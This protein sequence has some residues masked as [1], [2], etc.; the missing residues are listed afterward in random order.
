MKVSIEFL[1]Y[2]DDVYR[3]AIRPEDTLLT[4]SMDTIKSLLKV[5][6]ID[7]PSSLPFMTLFIDVSQGKG[8]FCAAST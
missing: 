5:Y 4:L 7:V 3:Y 8:V 1:Y 2:P 6:E